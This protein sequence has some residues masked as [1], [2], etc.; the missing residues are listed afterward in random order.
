MKWK[1]NKIT[2][3]KGI[4]YIATI[5]NEAGCIFNKVDGTNDVGIDGY[6][7]F[8]ENGSTT[9]LCIGIQ[10]KSGDSNISTDKIQLKSNKEHFVYWQN[11]ILPTCGI[12]YIPSHDKAYWIDIKSYIEER[13]QIINEGPYQIT[14][15]INREFNL[16][17]FAL[18][19]NNFKTYKN[20]YNTD[21]NFGKALKS[22]V[23]NA[24]ESR[25]SGIRALFSFH[26]DEKEAWF[27]IINHFTKEKDFNIQKYLIYLMSLIVGHGDIYWHKGNI[28]NQE[29]R[30][31]AYRTIIEN[32]TQH[33][34]KRL[35][36]NIDED[37]INRGTIGQGIHAIIETIPNFI[38]YLKT[39][40]IKDDI[41]DEIRANAAIII[42]YK[43]QFYDKPRAIRFC[44]SMIEHFPDSE[45][46]ESFE[47]IKEQIELHDGFAIY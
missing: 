14:L 27:Y 47:I 32:F 41:S 15:D 40:I 28:I 44:E 6:I 12:V 46:K 26:R 16:E 1:D 43:L 36:V 3:L 18:F 23:S 8:V 19:H 25:F 7:E 29:S 22:L 17:S 35:L 33:E 5:I 4:N 9:G 13:P 45:Y 2:E 39:I 10:V 34:V 38:S 11:H 20:T 42:T 37:G 31:Y 21:S 30:T 24:A